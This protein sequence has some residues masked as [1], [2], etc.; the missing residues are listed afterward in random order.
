MKEDNDNNSKD[1]QSNKMKDRSIKESNFSG[2]N[3]GK[4]LYE[5]GIK[6]KER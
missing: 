4:K 2:Y 1:N 3:H 6:F 5:R